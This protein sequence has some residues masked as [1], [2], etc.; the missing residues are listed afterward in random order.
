MQALLREEPG[1]GGGE[2]VL[3]GIAL[4]SA[5]AS[6]VRFPF[7]KKVPVLTAVFLRPLAGSIVRAP[8]VAQ[9]CAAFAAYLKLLESTGL[10]RLREVQAFLGL[11]G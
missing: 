3:R 11:C 7:P 6:L 5:L 8:E 1:A 2:E 4:P 9:R 10:W